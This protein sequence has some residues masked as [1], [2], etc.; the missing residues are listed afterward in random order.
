MCHAAQRKGQ[1]ALTKNCVGFAAKIVFVGAD[2]FH[3]LKGPAM[4]R[5]LFLSLVAALGF[6]G[7]ITGAITGAALAQTSDADALFDLVG[8]PQIVAI[9]RDEGLDYGETIARDMFPAG[10]TPRWAAQLD[11]IYDTDTM[12]A[13]MRQAFVAALDGQDVSGALDFYGSDLGQRIV[14][15]EIAA[16]AAM[17][18]PTIDATSK[19]FA[20]EQAQADTPR[21]RLINDFIVANDLIEANVVGG[22]NSNFAFIDA[23]VSGGATLPGVTADSLLADVWAQEDA[24]RAST[25]EW[26]T[27]FLL[28]AYA[29]LEDA[30]IA[31]LTSF[32]QTP[33]GRIMTQ[34]V[35]TAF[36]EIF[37]L[38]ARD[39]GSAASGFIISQDL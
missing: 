24:I 21:Y 13:Q 3:A 2:T 10:M 30:E 5:R 9:M 38:V 4:F 17:L 20:V 28:L 26:I 23:L 27:A 22:L 35:F 33:A 31:E 6:T 15:L 34:A 19:E 7:A 36:D 25:A 14:T 29:P 12:V 32:S 11:R 16:R 37:V 18:D 8:L 1:N 39:L